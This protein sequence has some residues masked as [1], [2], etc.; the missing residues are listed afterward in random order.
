MARPLRLQ[1]PGIRYPMTARGNERKEI[2]HGEAI[3]I[4]LESVLSAL[5]LNATTLGIPCIYYGTE[6][7]F[8][9]AGGDDRY[10]R[11]SMFGGVFGAF[12]THDLHFF[13]EE[14]ANYRELAKILE[15]R[16]Q[17]MI[18]R[19]GRQYLREISGNGEDFGLPQMLGKEMRSVVPWSRLFDDREMLLSINT[20]YSNS[21]TAWVRI[22]NDLH[23]EGE[24]LTCLYSTDPAQIGQKVTIK[25]AR[26]EIKAVVLTVPPAG[27]VI[28][29]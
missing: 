17:K 5:A 26:E 27:F 12:R 11:E 25:Q 1:Y 14:G 21:R 16:A 20:D 29:E 9:G 2:F 15:I 19:R 8:D 24:S 22:E 18:L 23:R 13:D 28:Y 7:S 10:I 3:W 6:Q 4:T